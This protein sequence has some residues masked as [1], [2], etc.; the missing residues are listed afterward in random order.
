MK[1]LLFVFTFSCACAP[2]ENSTI[3]PI[4]AEPPISVLKPVVEMDAGMDLVEMDLAIKTDIKTDMIIKEDSANEVDSSV[5]AGVLPDGTSYLKIVPEDKNETL[6]DVIYGYNGMFEN[7]NVV[8]KM[9]KSSMF[10]NLKHS[11]YAL[12]YE[13]VSDRIWVLSENSPVFLKKSEMGLTQNA[14]MEFFVFFPE[15]H[16]CQDNS[17]WAEITFSDVNPTPSAFTVS[18]FNFQLDPTIHC[19]KLNGLIIE[20]KSHISSPYP[21]LILQPW[22]SIVM[23]ADVLP[24]AQVLRFGPQPS[25]FDVI[26]T[27]L[28]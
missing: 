9:E 4:P 6:S 19:A 20:Q 11:D 13:I 28:Y 12:V 1:T 25:S 2:K 8:I 16:N 7:D 14:V 5:D 26:I 24:G 18:E 10:D 27:N 17:G 21:L 22:P 23:E 15:E 3:S